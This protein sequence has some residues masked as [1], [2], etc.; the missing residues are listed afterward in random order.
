MSQITGTYHS[1]LAILREA[2][3]GVCILAVQVIEEDAATAS[4]LIV[5]V[6]D[7]KVVITPLLELGPVLRVMLI[8]DS[9]GQ[10][11][12]N[13]NPKCSCLSDNTIVT[14]PYT[15]LR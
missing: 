13:V 14:I 12:A 15:V 11:E 2:E 6:L 8:T 10:H 5:A 4:A 9:L 3:N 7:H 1:F